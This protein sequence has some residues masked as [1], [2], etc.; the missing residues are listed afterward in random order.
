MNN[1]FTHDYFFYSLITLLAILVVSNIFLHW[2]FLNTSKKLKIFFAGKKASDL[3]GVLF[4][5]IK[6][7]KQAESNI[8]S[9]IESSEFLKKMAEKSIQKIA[10]IRFNPFRKTGGDQSF[11][12]ALLDSSDSGLIVSALYTQQGTR[13][14]C[15]PIK[16][17]QSEY[18]LSKEELKAIE[19]AKL[20]ST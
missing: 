11:S 1:L 13:I 16:N 12:I 9:L 8:E 17:S 15:K 5:E 14:Y 20:K 18:P 7:L 2:R 3:E 19:K 4:E 6:R 10:V